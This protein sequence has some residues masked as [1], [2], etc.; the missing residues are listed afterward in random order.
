LIFKN[1][2]DGSLSRL[3]EIG[4]HPINVYSSELPVFSSV[5]AFTPSIVYKFKTV[6]EELFPELFKSY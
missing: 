3:G 1:A 5:I 2:Y 6:K 4:V